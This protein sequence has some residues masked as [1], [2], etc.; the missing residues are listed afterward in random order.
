MTTCDPFQDLEA[1]IN[2][3]CVGLIALRAPKRLTGCIVCGGQ[4]SPRQ[5][6]AMPR[7]NG[8]RLASALLSRSMERAAVSP[9]CADHWYE[10]LRFRMSHLVDERQVVLAWLLKPQIPI[11][12]KEILSPP[13]LDYSDDMDFRS[14]ADVLAYTDDRSMLSAIFHDQ[15]YGKSNAPREPQASAL[16]DVLHRQFAIDHIPNIPETSEERW[17]EFHAFR[18]YRRWRPGIG[19][20]PY[21]YDELSEADQALVDRYDPPA[22]PK[23][24]LHSLMYGLQSGT[25]VKVVDLH[26]ECWVQVP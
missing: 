23:H 3:V 17:F 16:N 4:S 20:P 18:R 1:A 5:P 8:L 25:M 15:W 19:S 12:Q 11:V 6:F 14:V 9:L 7:Q 2:G 10:Y 24:P 21:D 22:P 26:G 13:D